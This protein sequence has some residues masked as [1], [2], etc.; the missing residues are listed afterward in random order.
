MEAGSV[1]G[2]MIVRERRCPRV[3]RRVR[4]A[5]HQMSRFPPDRRSLANANDDAGAEQNAR[6]A[7]Q[8]PIVSVA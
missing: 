2:I 3:D 5:R 1:A 4:R 6:R 7:K 8:H